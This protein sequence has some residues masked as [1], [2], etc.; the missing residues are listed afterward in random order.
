MKS[1]TEIDPSDKA[2]LLEGRLDDPFRVLGRHPLGDG[3]VVVRAFLPGVHEAE[4]VETGEP[5]R[6]LENG[7][8][9]EWR[10]AD[11]SLPRPYRIRWRI[12]GKVIERFDPYA[13]C[14]QLSDADLESFGRGDHFRA[15]RFLGAHEQAV[16]GVDG[17]LFAVW[18]PESERVSVIGDFNNWDGRCHPMRVRNGSGVWE[19]FIP[20]LAPEQ[21]YKYEIR[22]RSTGSVRI[23]FD[24]FAQKHEYRPATASV[25]TRSTTYAWGDTAWIDERVRQDWMHRAMSI[26]EVHLGSWRRSSA[27]GV[28]T[29]REM[30][31]QLVPYVRELGFTH[32]EL[33]PVTEHPLD[34]SWGYQ[35]TGYFAPTRRFGEPDDLRHLIDALHRNGIGVILD[36]VPG[37]FPRDEHGLARFD[38]SALFEYADP[39]RGDHKE[40]GTLIFN[41]GR[42][43]VRSFLISS[44]LCWLED[45]HFDGLRVDAVSA[46]LY[47]D[48]SRQDGEWVPNV[49][50]GNENLEAIAFL[51]QLNEV[52][53][54]QVPGSF[55]IAEESTAWPGVTKP[56]HAG[57]LG[58]S[59]KWNMGWMHDTLSYMSK[60]PIDRRH[61]H[62]QITFGPMYAFS[63]NFVLP[64]SH[65]EVVHMKQSLLGKMPGDDWQRFANLRLTYTFQ[66][67]Y[68]GKK[69]L[70][71][72]SELAQPDEWN[73]AGTAPWHLLDVPAH[74]GVHRLVQDLNGLYRS[75]PALFWYDF[76]ARGFQW[77][78]WEDADNSVLIYLRRADQTCV[79][80]ALNFTPIPRHGYRIGV[81]EKGAY[82][83][84]FNS[85]SRFYGGTDVGNPSEMP[86]EDQPAMDQPYSIGVT[87]PP[88]AGIILEKI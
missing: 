82:R 69:L 21:L 65:D 78:H 84:I 9:F 7:D 15:H 66:W 31:E 19:L 11:E 37:H 80:V 14:P 20:G 18:A 44:A 41:H 63:E 86:A 40:W 68:P 24:P 87:L 46:M 71:M 10:G 85:D 50:G 30:A 34:E 5:M 45:F 83:E 32:V 13:F 36:W 47:L 28:L 55:T 43:E 81:P 52:T 48:Y 51:K 33:L 49:H 35:T 56:T 61:H 2:R 60:P 23:K 3:G 57:G 26:Y 75:R 38:G 53:H 27:G 16:D 58:F 22:N 39:R 42:N 4:I 74:R 1:G 70:F 79:S 62:K 59:M 77:L 67:T 88:L 72:G 64:L 12:D 6:R 29:Y 17:F 54:G 76:A 8:L 25:T 73:S